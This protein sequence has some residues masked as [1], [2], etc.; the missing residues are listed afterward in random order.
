MRLR[1][2]LVGIEGL[3]LLRRLYD[4]TDSEADRRL[5][6]IRQI[7]DDDSFAAGEP[8]A[9]ADAVAG[10]RSWS[11]CYDE[12][13][14]QII[15]LEE[16]VV[17]SLVDDEPPGRALDAAC[18]TGRHAR[19]LAALG[20]RVVGTDLSRDMLLHAPEKAPGAAFTEA[21][22]LALPLRDRSFDLAVCGLALAHVADLGTAVGEL[23]RVLVPG[24]PLV[25]SV[26]HPF[27]A[28]LAWHA[29]FRDEHGHRRFVR[30]HPHTHGDYLT[31][32]RD[33]CFEVEAC[34]EPVLGEAG[35]RAKE[36]AYRHVPEATMAAYVDLPA[37]LV[38]KVRK[39][40]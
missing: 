30:E 34:V 3:A 28:H 10:Y 4:G 21:D 1:E 25:V 13:G 18:G 15:A 8:T 35:V 22:V 26:L 38:W 27:Q 40:G 24:A 29:P 14:N 23:G 31:A 5:R 20:H 9:E 12:P 19:H 11:Q 16:P 7:L 17:W 2:L 39:A 32:F 37:V 36:R 6:E 33:A